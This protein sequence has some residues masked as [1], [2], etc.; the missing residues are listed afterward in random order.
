MGRNLLSR[1]RSL[2]DVDGQGDDGNSYDISWTQDFS[3][4]FLGCHHIAVYNSNA[5]DDNDVRIKTQRHVRFRLCPTTSC[6][7][8]SPVGCTKKYGDYIIDMETFLYYYLS[9]QNEIKEE[10]C[11]AQEGKCNCGNDDDNADQCKYNCFVNAG[12]SQCVEN[13]DD[14][15][16][17]DA[18]ELEDYTACAQYEVDGHDEDE[19]QKDEGEDRKRKLDEEVNYFIGPYCAQG[20]SEILLGM[21]TDDT[22]TTFADSNGGSSTFK[23]MTG[24]ALPYES[25]SVVSGECSNCYK[26]FY[27]DDDAAEAG[28]REG[29]ET[30]Y[31]SSGKCETKLSKVTS[32]VNENACN[33]IHGITVTPIKSNGV[34]SRTYHG[35]KTAS[36]WIAFFATTFIM[37]AFYVCFLRNKVVMVLAAAKARRGYARNVSENK[38]SMKRK[39][40]FGRMFRKKKSGKSRVGS[41]DS[42]LS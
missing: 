19:E 42:L 41:D 33:Y 7:A 34:M 18:I 5:D 14:D 3:L 11:E 36:I 21:F 16:N 17:K 38:Q 24:S 39:W 6:S 15:A 10:L 13:N 32:S 23:G 28:L 8:N 27:N 9:N 12:L 20:G 2:E 31:K 26:G 25:T 4:K 1:A 37:M 30:M 22:C 29:C 40:S 35:S